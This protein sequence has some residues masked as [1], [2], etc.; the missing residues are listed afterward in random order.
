MERIWT[1]KPE[2]YGG[3]FGR[4]VPILTAL[5][6]IAAAAVSES[7]VNGYSIAF[8]AAVAAGCL[9]ARDRSA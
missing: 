7:D 5:L 4:I 1:G 6:F 2:F 8:F 3:A 9:C